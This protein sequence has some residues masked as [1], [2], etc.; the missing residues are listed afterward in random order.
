MHAL[1]RL[2]LLSLLLLV[3]V[4]G[5]RLVTAQ[6]TPVVIT[7]EGEAWWNGGVC[8]EV[9]V[10]SFSDSDGDGIGDLQGLIE[11]LDYLN[12]GDPA[13][14]TD[15]GVSC[16]WL[17]PIFESPSYHG[18]DVTDY[19]TIDADYG[20][21]ADFTALMA[22]AHERGIKVL[23]DLVLNHTSN[24]HPWFQAALN[25]PGSPYRDWYIFVDESPGYLG[26]WAQGVWHPSPVGD[27]YYYGI[28]VD[29]MPD[30]NYRNPA[31]TEEARNISRFW[32]EEMGADGFRLDAIKHLI[33]DGTI[34]E[35]TPQTHE[36]IRQYHDF[37]ATIA[38]EAYTVGE[39]GGSTVQ[40]L[41]PYYAAQLTSY[42][43]FEIGPD[44][45]SAATAADATAFGVSAQEAT[46]DLPNGGW[47]P[48]LTNHDQA[49]TMSILGGDPDRARDR[50]DRVADAAGHTV[51]LLRRRDRAIRG[52]TG[53]AEADT[54]A[55]AGRGRGRLYHRRAVGSVAARPGDRERGGADGCPRLVAQSVPAPDS[56]ASGGA[57]AGAG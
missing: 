16:L 55:V 46:L 8:Y 56:P 9:F 14:T 31:V 50:G 48:F 3:D 24:E 1:V 26:P 45:L 25:D 27:D 41:Q 49:R 39:I 54:D 32:L 52:G 22:A 30:L 4:N 17:M 18:Y 15:L 37:L 2:A 38:P 12:D 19:Y 23:L 7:E 29:T 53:R 21:N 51:R 34:Q 35:N 13:T 28:F 44:I 33:E 40:A 10:R 20:T 57:G 42:F 11:K 36:W 43:D 6:G 47:A 5:T